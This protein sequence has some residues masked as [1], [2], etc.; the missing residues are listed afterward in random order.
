M[1]TRSKNRL[2]FGVYLGTALIAIPLGAI[3]GAFVLWCAGLDPLGGFVCGSVLSPITWLVLIQF[4]D[5]P[6]WRRAIVL[7]LISL[8][9]GSAF[10]LF[11]PVFTLLR[12]WYISIPIGVATAALIR[13][14]V[15][16][17]HEL[18]NDQH[19]IQ[20]GYD[21]MGNVSDVC[22]ECGTRVDR[23]PKDPQSDG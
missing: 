20:C 15:I 19:C 14:V 16:H 12:V 4:L 22:P 21:L 11:L 23:V 18:T 6:T 13:L 8:I 7:G 1:K 9:V 17:S 2:S 5:P 3:G 10:Y